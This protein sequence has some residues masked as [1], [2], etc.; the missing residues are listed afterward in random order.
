MNEF[1]SYCV[2]C[3]ET[4]LLLIMLLSLL[5][6]CCLLAFCCWEIKKMVLY[7]LNNK[8]KI[9]RNHKINIYN[10]FVQEKNINIYLKCRFLYI[11]HYLR[12]KCMLALHNCSS[13]GIT[14]AWSRSRQA[15][16][17]PWHPL[18]FCFLLL[19]R[20]SENLSEEYYM[21][22]YAVCCHGIRTLQSVDKCQQ[23]T[24]R[25]QMI[26]IMKLYIV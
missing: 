18:G 3:L 14:A 10:Q 9:K 16:W 26:F 20:V 7:W 22:P 5:A 25:P 21:A 13:F 23:E 19:G 1:M 12:W 2:F 24:L 4:D 15:V 17:W 6:Y 8:K 11:R